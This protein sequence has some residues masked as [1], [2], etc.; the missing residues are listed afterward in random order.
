MSRPSSAGQVVPVAA[1]EE[2]EEEEPEVMEYE[3][4]YVPRWSY[5]TCGCIGS[6]EVCCLTL[7]CPCVAYGR[8][9]EAA[10]PD[11]MEA[12]DVK[13]AKLKATVAYLCCAPLFWPC[14]GCYRRQKLAHHYKIDMIV[15]EDLLCHILCHP[16][17][18]CQEGREVRRREPNGRPEPIQVRSYY[19]RLPCCCPPLAPHRWRCCERRGEGALGQPIDSFRREGARGDAGWESGGHTGRGE[20]ARVRRG[21]AAARWRGRG[22]RGGGA[23]GR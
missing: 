8:L 21:S 18:M 13:A 14:L 19:A 9:A 4:D 10:Q 23:N 17:S 15:W 6:L 5:G 2:E 16:C 22:R 3:F 12:A 20:S 7:W 11:F 1:E